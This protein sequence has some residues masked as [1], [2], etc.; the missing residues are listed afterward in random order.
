[1]NPYY[2]THP[3]IPKPLHGMNPRT[4]LG[5]EWWDEKRQEA[6]AKH[7]YHCWACGIHKRYAAFHQWLEGHESYDINYRT[8]RVE[9]KEIIA[10]C[11]ICHNF[12]HSGRMQIMYQ[13]GKMS[14]NKIILILTNGF[15]ILDQAGLEPFY[16]T[17]DFWNY[18][19]G[20]NRKAVY[21][22]ANAKDAKWSEWHLVIEGKK[23]YS[24][25]KDIED[26]R[27]HYGS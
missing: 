19:M 15:S 4:L 5:K 2:L 11:H 10:L 1:M 25:F 17:V 12:I 13:K 6:Y 27:E 7:D 21:P 18:L 23:Y 9:L 22:P 3:N 20:D 8:G 14:R 26:W 24:Q 16:G